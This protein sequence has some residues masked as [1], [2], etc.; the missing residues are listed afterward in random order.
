M[1]KKQFLFLWIMEIFIAAAAAVYVFVKMGLSW[2]EIFD[3]FVFTFLCF[4]AIKGLFF[5]LDN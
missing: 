1:K 5:I 3:I 2:R 4:L